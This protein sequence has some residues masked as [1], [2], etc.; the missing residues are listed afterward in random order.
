MEVIRGWG[1]QSGKNLVRLFHVPG[2][3]PCPS[4]VLAGFLGEPLRAQI[5]STLISYWGGGVSLIVPPSGA[6]QGRCSPMP[7]LSLLS[8]FIFCWRQETLVCLFVFIFPLSQ[9]PSRF[10]LLKF[11]SLFFFFSV[12][13][14]WPRSDPLNREWSWDNRT[15]W[16][17]EKRTSVNISKYYPGLFVLCRH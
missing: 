16:W 13:M 4:W 5:P 14:V 9:V 3:S 1:M 17:K 15:Y 8:L 6:R 7:K 10:R 2:S 11:K 12:F